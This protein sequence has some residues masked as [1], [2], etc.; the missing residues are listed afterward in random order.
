M[1][2]ELIG[3]FKP[4]M[5]EIYLHIVARMTEIYLAQD[6]VLREHREAHLLALARAVR[7]CANQA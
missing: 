4:C 6:I 3:H 5:T 7:A 2:V 1:R